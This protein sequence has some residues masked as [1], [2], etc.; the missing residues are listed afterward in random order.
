MG[1]GITFLLLPQLSATLFQSN[2]HYPDVMLRTIGMFMI[3]LGILVLQMIRLRVENM[4]PATLIARIF[5]C[6][7]LVAFYLTTKDPLFLVLCA[8]VGLGVIITGYCYFTE[9]A[10]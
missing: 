2:G 3:V 5:I 8:I 6:I 4:Y 1:R 9:K 7:T 10:K